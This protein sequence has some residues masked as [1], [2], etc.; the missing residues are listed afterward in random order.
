M[1]HTPAFATTMFSLLPAC[2]A[3][4]AN[5]ATEAGNDEP[6]AQGTIV[7]EI[8]NS[9]WYVFQDKDGNYWFGS[10]GKGV[11]RYDGKTITR[12]TTQDGLSHDHI[13]GIQQ[14]APTGDILITTLGDVSKFDGHRFVT[15]PVTEMDSP[16]DGWVLN[17]E[18]VWLPWQPKQRGPYRYDGKT[19]YHL[20]FPKS[21]REDAY[22]AGGPSREWSPYEVYCV[23]KDKRGHVWFGTSNLG[24]YRFDGEHV[25][26]MYEDHLT[27]T[28]NGGSFGI[29]SILEDRRG[30]FW[31]CNTQYRYAMRPRGDADG[32][33][34]IAYSREPGMDL[35][36]SPLAE[37]FFYFQSITED[38]RGHLWMAPYAGG[39]FEYDG[40]NVRHYPMKDAE[41]DE[42]TM[43]TIYKD[44][45]GDLWVGTHEHGAFKFNGK[46]FERFS[47]ER[48]GR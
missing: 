28:P 4:S 45:R 23:Y 42:I 44:R 27:N 43:F 29:R 36:R 34:Q 32:P 18:D 5:Q 38:D 48:G 35:S 39:V 46:E 19:L 7:S 41:N 26:W 20:E 30:D 10:D 14:H 9:C 11:S 8:D 37:K 31:F 6:P 2:A 25:D 22:Y 40:T 15:L 12:F 3:A 47:V 13:R 1:K 21:P 24:I 17:A 16:D 33:G